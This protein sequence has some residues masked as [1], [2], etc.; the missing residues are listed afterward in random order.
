[1]EGKEEKL[2]KRKNEMKE[3][4]NERKEWMAEIENERK[5]KIFQIGHDILRYFLSRVEHLYV[6]FVMGRKGYEKE[7][8][9]LLSPSN[10][11]ILS[12]AYREDNRVWQV[13]IEIKLLKT[14]SMKI[15]YKCYLLT[16][17]LL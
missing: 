10:F 16:I 17:A 5:K 4:L 12:L 8:R 11:E 14:D 7:V 6:A 2:L 15:S 9:Y 1:M 3:K 13:A